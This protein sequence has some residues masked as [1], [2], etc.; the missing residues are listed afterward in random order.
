MDSEENF[1]RGF[2]AKAPSL[3]TEDLDHGDIRHSTDFRS[4]YSTVLEKVLQTLA[5]GVLGRAF[6]KAEILA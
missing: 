2:Y 3:K 1:F 5:Q 6:P 4:V